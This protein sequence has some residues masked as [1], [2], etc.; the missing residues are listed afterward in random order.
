[1]NFKVTEKLI[2]ITNKFIN[3]DNY[4]IQT[5]R[6]KDYQGI[7][8]TADYVEII[9][10]THNSVGFEV[11]EDE[12]IVFFFTD[13]AHFNDY[14]M[15]LKDNEPD[16]IERAAEFLEKLFIL[17]IERKYTVKGTTVV[18]E[19]SLFILS[20]TEKE[21]CAGVTFCFSGIKNIFKKKR[22]VIEVKQFDKELGNFTTYAEQC[23]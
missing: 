2:S 19:E 7:E 13:H 22:R 12:I 4:I 10:D 3:A 15:D 23:I 5:E 11:T 8:Y 6:H 18:R 9:S 16:Y 20:Q 17:P 14:G 1:M 21:S